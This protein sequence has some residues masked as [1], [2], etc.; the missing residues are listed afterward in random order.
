MTKQIILVIAMTIIPGSLLHSRAFA[1]RALLHLI[2]SCKNYFYSHFSQTMQLKLA[3]L[4]PLHIE[5]L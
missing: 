2:L 3:R 1:E 4:M 5:P